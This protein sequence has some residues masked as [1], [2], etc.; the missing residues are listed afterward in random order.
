MLHEYSQ[1]RS[2]IFIRYLQ[3]GNWSGWYD[4]ADGGNAA[5][6]GTYT[7][8]KIAALEARIAALEGGNV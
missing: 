5:S 4:I 8:A 7:E 2:K 3:D 1:Q 6:V